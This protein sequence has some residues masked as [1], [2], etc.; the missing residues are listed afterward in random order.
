MVQLLVVVPEGAV[1]QA[2]AVLETHPLI[3]NN[4]IRVPSR[5]QAP[6]TVIQ[7]QAP[8]GP[9][10]QVQVPEGAVPGTQIQVEVDGSN[11]E[12]PEPEPEPESEPEPGATA[13]AMAASPRQI[14]VTEVAS[15]GGG[16]ARRSL[17]ETCEAL[18]A[19]GPWN[20]AHTSTHAG[21]M[22]RL[23][24]IEDAGLPRMRVRPPRGREHGHRHHHHPAS[25]SLLTSPPPPLP[26]PHPTS[27]C[28]CCPTAS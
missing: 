25:L 4:T 2:F 6:G 10:V 11:V 5:P 26:S 12:A 21:L 3:T 17:G 9:I 7:I 20:A 18:L 22:R 23:K 16:A 28:R 27:V 1:G 24:M 15:H 14:E 19:S 8:G 13:A